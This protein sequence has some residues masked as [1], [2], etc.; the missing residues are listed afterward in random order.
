MY[1]IPILPLVSIASFPILESGD[2]T[3]LRLECTRLWYSAVGCLRE[4]GLKN[5]NVHLTISPWTQV[6]LVQH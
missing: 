5:G 2:A 4:Q 1:Y 6:H 3:Y